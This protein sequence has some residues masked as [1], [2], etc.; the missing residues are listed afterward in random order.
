MKKDGVIMTVNGPIPANTTGI[1]LEHEHILVDFIGADSI[2]PARWDDQEVVL[3]ALPFLRKVKES[4]CSTFIDCTP[5]YLGRDPELL[6]SLSSASGL[7]IITN[8]G[9]YGA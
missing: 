1:T 5:A 8:T 3:I 4:G 7:N 6:K 9:L 2:N